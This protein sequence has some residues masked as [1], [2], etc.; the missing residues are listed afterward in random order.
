M[1]LP[2]NVNQLGGDG[3][4]K[5]YKLRCTQQIS[6]SKTK[7]VRQPGLHY[8]ERRGNKIIKEGEFH[9]QTWYWKDSGFGHSA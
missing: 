6:D 1:K 7:L 5:R 9:Q 3:G 8:I 4:M 2:L